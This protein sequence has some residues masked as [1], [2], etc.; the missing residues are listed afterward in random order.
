MTRS[1][2]GGGASRCRGD[3]GITM[4]EMMVT[5]FLALVILGTTGTTMVLGL[6]GSRTSMVRT[7]NTQDAS[8]ILERMTKPLRMAIRPLANPPTAPFVTGG[9]PATGTSTDVTFYAAINTIVGSDMPTGPTKYRFY[10]DTTTGNLI[11]QITPVTISGG[12]FTWPATTTATYT[13]GMGLTK[14]QSIF[15]YY[16]DNNVNLGALDATDA[17]TVDSVGLQLSVDKPTT[18]DVPP[19]VV[20]NRVNLPNHSGTFIL[21]TG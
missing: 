9:T 16:D 2:R 21:P 7:Q 17:F 5:I 11:E 19:T 14:T 8:L 13:I 20:V 15:T 12:L 4:V 3:A 10:L 1:L 18:P 6:R